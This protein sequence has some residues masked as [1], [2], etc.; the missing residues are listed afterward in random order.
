MI[1]NNIEISSRHQLLSELAEDL[2]EL[3]DNQIYS[4]N[5]NYEHENELLK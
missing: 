4:K 2:P 5:Q 1:D 3:T